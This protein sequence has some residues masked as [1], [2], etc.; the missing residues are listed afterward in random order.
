MRKNADDLNDATKKQQEVYDEV[1]RLSDTAIS[2]ILE[3]NAISQSRYSWLFSIG[4]LVIGFFVGVFSSLVATHLY[5]K[6][7]SLWRR[8]KGLSHSEMDSL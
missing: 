8:I 6:P 2:A 4:N 3:A 7:P 5:E 1:S